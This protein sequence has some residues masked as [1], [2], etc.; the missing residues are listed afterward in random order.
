MLPLTTTWV[1][2]RP[3]TG[4]SRRSKALSNGGRLPCPAGARTGRGNR[5]RRGR[6]DV[7]RGWCAACRAPD[8]W[9]VGSTCRLEGDRG[10][11][12]APVHRPR[13]RPGPHGQARPA[14]PAAV[15]RGAPRRAG[16]DSVGW[17]RDAPGWRIECRRDRPAAPAARSGPGR[18]LGPRVPAPRRWGR[19]AR[20]PCPASPWRST[21]CTRPWWSGRREDVQVQ[22]EPASWSSSSAGAG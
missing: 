9:V 1:P 18:R 8:A 14:G 4:S 17:V 15:A 19:G 7:R 22:G 10:A 5:P 13:G 11:H 20:T 6:V 12:A 16:V 3:S 2:P 21:S